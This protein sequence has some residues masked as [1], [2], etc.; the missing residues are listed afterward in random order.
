MTVRFAE[1]EDS[2][3]LLRIYGE[4]IHTPVTFEY[5]LPTEEEFGE[6]IRNVKKEGY[7]YLVWEEDGRIAGYAYAHRA[8]ERAAYQWDAELSIY[9]AESCT[10]RGAGGKL[11]DMLLELLKLQGVRTVYG[12]VVSPNPRSERLHE[13]MGFRRIGLFRDTG[14]KNGEW[15]DVVWFEKKI[16]SFEEQPRSVRPVWEL[17]KKDVERILSGFSR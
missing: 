6:R 17:E 4:Y 8:F 13:R 14:Y 12:C 3:E 11:Y 2:R 5:R 15:L 7:P 16:G 9:L 10:C 1:E